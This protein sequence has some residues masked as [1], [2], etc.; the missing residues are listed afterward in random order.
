MTHVPHVFVKTC[1][2][3][4]RAK[5][6]DYVRRGAPRFSSSDR[7]SGVRRSG[8]CDLPVPRPLQTHGCPRRWSN[9]SVTFQ[10]SQAIQVVH[11]A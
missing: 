2:L 1:D 8:S 9:S 5:V 3:F 4:F 7:T 11:D 10:R 6:E